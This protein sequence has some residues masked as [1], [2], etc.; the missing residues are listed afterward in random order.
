MRTFV[1]TLA[2]T[3]VGAGSAFAGFPDVSAPATMAMP[4][5]TVS[6]FNDSGGRI[7]SGEVVVWD[8]ADTDLSVD[9][10]P[11]VT[12]STTVDDPQ[13]AGVIYDK[14]GCAD[15]TVC[16]IVV[17]GPTLVRCADSSDNVSVDTYVGTASIDGGLCGDYTSAADKKPLGMALN[18]GSGT[19]Y[20]Y[21]PV[22]VTTLGSGP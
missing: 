15:Q 17:Y 12:T 7:E 18:N 21:I 5:V 2:L 20:E 9:L 16:D 4:V 22:F 1:V 6:V 11:F 13:T 10:Q 14:A 19:N 3:L 8:S